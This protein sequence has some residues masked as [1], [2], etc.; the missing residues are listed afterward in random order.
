M[1][2]FFGNCSNSHSSIG[3]D[4]LISMATEKQQVCRFDL[5]SPASHPGVQPIEKGIAHMGKPEAWEGE[6]GERGR[7][8][9]AMVTQAGRV[10]EAEATAS[11]AGIGSGIWREQPTGSECSEGRSGAKSTKGEEGCP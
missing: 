10:S 6:L 1:T 8:Q 3:H 4:F 11:A 7:G 9:R 5:A 2:Y